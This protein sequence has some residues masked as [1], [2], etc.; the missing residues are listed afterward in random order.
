ML[1]NGLHVVGSQRVLEVSEY[2]E[3][4]LG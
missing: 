2:V 1:S 3:N 4:S